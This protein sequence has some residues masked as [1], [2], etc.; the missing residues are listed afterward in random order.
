MNVYPN[1]VSDVFY[2]DFES[3]KALALQIDIYDAVGRKVISGE[4]VQVMG[5]TTHSIDATKLTAGTYFI[6]ISN[7]VNLVTSK[8]LKF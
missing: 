3:D 7:G 4:S 2:M 8:I 6:R 5:S 1:P